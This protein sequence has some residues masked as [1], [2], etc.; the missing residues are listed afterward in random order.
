M[1][2][3]TRT[4]TPI[5]ASAKPT[6]TVT[7]VGR[8]RAIAMPVAVI[9]PPVRTTARSPWRS[10]TLSPRSRPAVMAVWSET[11]ARPAV[12]AATPT[13]ERR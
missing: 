7:A 6:T 10:T 2:A 1:V 9:I 11:K 4:A 5:P 12:P 3:G 8:A 13:P